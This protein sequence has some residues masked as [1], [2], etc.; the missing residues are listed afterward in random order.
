MSCAVCRRPAGGLGYCRVPL[1]RGGTLQP[2]C[3]RRCQDILVKKQGMM[4]PTDEQEAFEHASDMAGEYL[5]ELQKTDLAT[6]SQ[7]EWLTLIG[8]IVN[9]FSAALLKI[10]SDE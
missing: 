4:N 2:A 7:E 1:S 3:S 5:E 8:V 10:R 6:F 9:G